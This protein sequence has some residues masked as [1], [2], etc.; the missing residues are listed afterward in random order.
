M[1]EDFTTYRVIPYN[2][3][4][5]EVSLDTECGIDHEFREALRRYLIGTGQLEEFITAKEME[6]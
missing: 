5:R 2:N 4:C 6:L 1:I 3:P